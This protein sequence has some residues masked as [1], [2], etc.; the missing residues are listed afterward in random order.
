MRHVEWVRRL[1]AELGRGFFVDQ[2][3]AMA[4]ASAEH[5]NICH[6]L[7]FALGCGRID[8]AAYIVAAVAYPWIMAGQPDGRHWADRTARHLSLRCTRP[9]PG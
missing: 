2:R 8:D 7:D 3:A 1:S 4:R 6:A 9:S 5:A